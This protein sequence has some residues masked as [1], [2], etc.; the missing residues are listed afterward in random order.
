MPFSRDGTGD[1]FVG[2]SP[3][4]CIRRG[5][6]GLPSAFT[7]IVSNGSLFICL[8]MACMKMIKLYDLFF[9]FLFTVTFR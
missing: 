4:L 7:G 1:G 6:L 8:N 2:F 9:F 5:S 3:V